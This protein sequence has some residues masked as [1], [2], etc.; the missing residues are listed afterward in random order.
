M[1]AGKNPFEGLWIDADEDLSV[2]EGG[3]EDRAMWSSDQLNLLL[4][5]P[6]FAG[7]QSPYRRH[8]P[9]TLLIR[10]ALYWVVL[11]AAPAWHA[12]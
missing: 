8:K 3:S 11:I 2:L 9:G 6:L 5:S 4:A 10:D 1:K 7:C 12:S